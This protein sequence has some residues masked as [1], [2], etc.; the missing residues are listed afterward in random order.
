MKVPVLSNLLLFSVLGGET[1]EMPSVYEVGKYDIA[2]YCVGIL[3]AG[4]ELPKFEQYEEG[5]LLISLPANGLHCAGF[6]ALLKQLEV[7][8]IDL[9]DRCEFADG[10]KTLGRYILVQFIS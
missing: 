6:H 2:G 5:D 4:K 10:T 8:G 9:T 1:A 3:E 7:A